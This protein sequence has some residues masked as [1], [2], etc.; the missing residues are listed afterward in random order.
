MPTVGIGLP[1]YNGERFLAQALES[2]LAQSWEDFELVISDNASSDGTEEICRAFAARDPR[3]R[4]LRRDVNRGAA[5]NFNSVV[6]ETSAPYFKWAAHDDLLAPTCVEQCLDALRAADHASLVYPRTRAI[7]E[8][9]DVVGEYHDGVDVRERLPHERLASLVRAL[10]F[11]NPAFGLTRR[12]TLQRTRLLGSFPSAD[13][14][15]LAE[16]ALLGEIHELPEYLFFRREHPGMSRRAN[17]TAAEVAEWFE[18]GSGSDRTHEFS[19]LFVEH[20]RAIHAMP[21]G[22]GE[23]ARCYATFGNVWLRRNGVHVAEELFGLEYTGGRRPFRR[24]R[25]T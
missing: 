7:D 17:A 9:G 12:A 5:W 15:L 24:R 13:Y 20:L 18:P 11:G 4:Y 2:L 3:V 25:R 8:D 6:H 16:L 22:R 14:V 1:V 19:R 21:L 10:V 23:R